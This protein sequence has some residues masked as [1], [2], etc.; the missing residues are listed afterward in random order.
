MLVRL[1][2]ASRA[3]LPLTAV[4]VDAILE[5]SRENNPR[6]GITGLLCFSDDVFI[7]VLEGGRDAV[8]ELYN[9]I[10]RDTRHTNVRLLIYEEIA[11]R[12][13]GGWVM[14]QVNVAR[15]N[16]AL[17]LKHAEKAA[18]DPFSCSGHASMALLDELVATASVVNRGS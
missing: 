13:F 1:L 2:Y 6:E 5:R 18:L 8:C 11:E 10:A 16:P 9:A 15:V 7:Q 12:R 14:G 3:A 4:V 17:L